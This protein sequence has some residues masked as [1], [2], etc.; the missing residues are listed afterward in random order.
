MKHEICWVALAEALGPR[1]PLLRPLLDRFTSPEDIFAADESALRE[2]VPGISQGVLSALLE[3]RSEGAAERIVTW[4]ERNGVRILTYDSESY[5]ASLRN[6]NEPPTVLY[7][8]GNLPAGNG[9][10]MLGVVGT[11]RPDAYGERVTYKLSFEM[12]ATGAVIVSGLA[13]GLDAI[14]SAAALNVGGETIAVL[15]CGIDIVYPRQH[16][17]LAAE[18]VKHGAILTEFAPGTKPNGWNFPIRNRII[19]ALSDGVVVV[20]ARAQS[21]ALI[22]ARYAILQGKAL[23]AVPGDITR[24]RSAGT[25][26]LL[27]NGALP[28]VDSAEVLEHFR[29]LYRDAIQMQVL[30]EAKRHSEP[31]AQSL[32]PFGL[33]MQLGTPT[34]MQA[35]EK[36]PQKVKSRHP[37]AEVVPENA[38]VIVETAPPD[39]SLLTPRQR[40]LYAL[41]P[42][43]PFTVD[44]LTAQGVPVAEAVSC[45]TIFEIY[46]LLAT[47]PGGFFEKK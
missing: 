47:R 41:L 28:A 35:E 29:F 1:S 5:P 31:S 24:P 44:V 19:S 46:G 33:R 14:A 9:R 22:T 12:A 38:P 18:I 10:L 20:E 15:G 16:T 30:N 27:V 36:P 42:A 23:F 6:I 43:E 11:R 8:R 40:E 34:R 2:A 7:C 4:C 39:T 37:K 32:R 13:E 21:G 3:K 25:N 45:L 17:R 26:A